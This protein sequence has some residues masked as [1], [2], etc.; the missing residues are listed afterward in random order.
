MEEGFISPGGRGIVVQAPTAQQLMA[1]LEESLPAGGL[2]ARA[3]AHT[4]ADYW[5]HSIIRP[6]IRAVLRQSCLRAQLGSDEGGRR[7][8]G[9]RRH[10]FSR[11]QRFRHMT[12]SL[13]VLQ[14][15]VVCA[16]PVAFFG[17]VPK[18]FDQLS[19]LIS[20]SLN[21]QNYLL[22]RFV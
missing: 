8:Q 17:V 3:R 2:R 5:M 21:T 1:K 15:H 18:T 4:H 12:F 20:R 14:G 10:W 22:A 16:R 11:N 7:R 13:A 19:V 9:C 6:G